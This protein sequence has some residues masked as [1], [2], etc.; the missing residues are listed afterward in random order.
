MPE[1][2]YFIDLH[3][4]RFEG[5]AVSPWVH[6]ELAAGDIVTIQGPLGA[7]SWREEFAGAPLLLVGT[8]TGIGALHGI[9]RDALRGGHEGPIT[10]LHGA[11][12]VDGLYLHDELNALAAAHENVTYTGCVSRGL[13]A[14]G[15]VPG[16]VIA[17]MFDGERA[18]EGLALYLCG[19]PEMVYDARVEAVRRG[20]KRSRIVAD[21]YESAEPYQPDDK[22]K[23]ATIAPDPELWDAL[24]QGAGLRAILYHFYTRAYEDIRL[25]PFFHNVTKQR[26]ISK[27]YQFLADIIQGRRDYF[28]FRPFNAHHWMIIS[29]DLFDYRE[30]LIEKSARFWGLAEEPLSRWMAI[31]EQ[32]RREIV[33]STS[34]GLIVDGVEKMLEGYSIE[35]VEV[36]TICDGCFQE[37]EVGEN[38]RMHRR[39][40]ELFCRACGGRP[41]VAG[42]DEST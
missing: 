22:G 32:F 31:H 40:G 9:A 34:R 20:V 14:P 12:G 10:I 11:R 1:E 38:A 18:P 30:E 8:G 36:A 35:L 6:D 15:T 13:P 25:A 24:D 27:Q 17:R 37:I 19:N 39:T 3:V 23:L 28:G 2:D 26:A 16:R 21:A 29:D 5:G 33:K 7:C 42:E 41:V 4:A